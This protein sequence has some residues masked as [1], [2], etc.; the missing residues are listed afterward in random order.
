MS[1][2]V[3]LPEKSSDIVWSE[4]SIELRAAVK[5]WTQEECADLSGA[6]LSGADLSGANLSGADLSGA[7]LS[8]AKSILALGPL[9]SRGDMLYAV[10]HKDEPRLKTG[11]FWGTIPEFEAAT[12]RTHGDNAH[13]QLY[14]AALAL[15]RTWY[16]AQDAAL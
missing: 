15:I 16:A 4:L 5:T 9:G 12:T 14:R 8:G 10:W 11:C 7:D 3:G 1:R 13:A 2:P 6:D